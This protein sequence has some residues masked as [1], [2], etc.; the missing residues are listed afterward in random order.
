M[1]SLE[2]YISLKK[3][4]LYE[5]KVAATHQFVLMFV[6]ASSHQ[7]WSLLGSKKQEAPTVAVSSRSPASTR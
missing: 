5:W 6:F 2:I 1:M 3:L 7:G 4:K